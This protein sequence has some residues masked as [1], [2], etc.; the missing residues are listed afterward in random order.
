M[1]APNVAREVQTLS[2]ELSDFLIEFAI[3]LNKHAIYPAGHPLLDASRAV[4][5]N[6]L[7][8]LLAT[9]ESISLGVAQN[10]FIIEGLATET[11]N[12]LLRELA[13]RLHRQHIAAIRISRGASGRELSEFLRTLA[14]DGARESP[15]G[16]RPESERTWDH[17]QLF[18]ITYKSLELDEAGRPAAP[19]SAA[20]LWIELARATLPDDGSAV[21]GDP[22]VVAQAINTRDRD[23]AYD[24]VVVGYL[25]Q[26]SEPTKR[27]PRR[28]ASASPISSMRSTR[29]P[30]SACSPWVASRSRDCSSCAARRTRS[31][32][33][34]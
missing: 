1:T 25:L 24:Q 34:P 32:P 8:T 3:V 6:R 12:A 22:S 29:K 7:T 26:L 17:I 10:Q 14:S 27:T 16:L 19:G 13:R 21:T 28:S 2:R 9:R 33:R 18:P 4:F 20:H 5:A 15:I 31:L 11:S 23:V 30:C